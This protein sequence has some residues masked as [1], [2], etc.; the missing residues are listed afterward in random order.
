MPPLSEVDIQVIQEVGNATVQHLVALVV[1]AVLWTV[2]LVLTCKAGLSLLSRQRRSRASLTI[3][4]IIVLM[5]LLDTTTSIIDVNNAIREVTLTLTSTS[6]QSFK[7]RYALTKSLPYPV[8]SALYAY[9]SNLGD[10]IIIWR[11]YA[12]WR[13]GREKWVLVLPSAFFLGS[14]VTSGLITFC[15]A[16]AV[17]NPAE[18]NF[19]DPPFC[20]NVQL[21]S[22]VTT[23]AT[24]A[25]ATLL[26]CYKTWYYRRT[27]AIHVRQMKSKKSVAERIMIIMIESGII[28]LLFFIEGVVS[29][30]RNISRLENS[31]PQLVFTITIW[32]YMTSHILGIYPVLI[33]LLVHCQKSYID[34]TTETLASLPRFATNHESPTRPR[35]YWNSRSQAQLTLPE[36]LHS[37]DAEGAPP[38]KFSMTL[39]EGSTTVFSAERTLVPEDID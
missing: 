30:T 13:D 34:D 22:Y 14:I 21:A 36:G 26:I 31:T 39:S 12:F 15:A 9:E 18:G 38:P 3:F 11:T 20:E 5:F 35:F 2:Y 37:R 4:F 7:E 28:Y 24:T 16:R 8:Q 10:A 27:I 23:L 32:T 25:V 17:Q 6:H 19:T 1:E 29:D 33:V